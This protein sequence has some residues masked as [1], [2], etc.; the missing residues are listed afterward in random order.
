MTA[1]SPPAT[2]DAGEHVAVCPKCWAEVT[3]DLLCGCDDEDTGPLCLN[4]C[5]GFWHNDR[6]LGGAA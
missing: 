2:D 1:A 3:T 5:C 4:R 6:A